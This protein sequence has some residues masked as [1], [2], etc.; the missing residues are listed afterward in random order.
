MQGGGGGGSG[1]LC[2]GDLEYGKEWAVCILLECI[3]VSNENSFL[4]IP[5]ANF[6]DL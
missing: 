6:L 1:G 2:Q 3:L 5:S 4:S